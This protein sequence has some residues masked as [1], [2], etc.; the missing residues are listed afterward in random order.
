LVQSPSDLLSHF[1]GEL[2]LAKLAISFLRRGLPWF[3]SPFGLLKIQ[4]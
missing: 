3:A 2:R 4:G 1:R